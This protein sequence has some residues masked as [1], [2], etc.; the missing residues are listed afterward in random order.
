MKGISHHD[1]PKGNYHLIKYMG[2]DLQFTSLLI[3]F[4]LIYIVSRH[5]RN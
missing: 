3:W 5:I 1:G 2:L 4:T